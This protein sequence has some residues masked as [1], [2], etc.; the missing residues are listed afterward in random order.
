MNNNRSEFDEINRPKHY[1]D[2]IIEPIE[3]ILDTLADPKSYCIGNV[4]KYIS[5]YDRKE[6]ALKDL[7][8]ARYYLNLAIQLE[9]DNPI[10]IPQEIPQE[11]EYND[12]YINGQAE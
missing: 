8:K 12:W 9:E 1:A 10:K 3:Y 6:N 5:R 7:K 2:K 11:D 4:I